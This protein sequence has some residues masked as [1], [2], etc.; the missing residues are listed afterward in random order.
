MKGLALII[1]VCT[2]FAGCAKDLS[3]DDPQRYQKARAGTRIDAPDDLDEL[4]AS[5]EL[6]V[7]SA[8]PRDARP[9]GSPCLDLPPVLQSKGI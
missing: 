1:M 5:K 9:D 4:E 3:C 7:P 2:V 6:T 8:S